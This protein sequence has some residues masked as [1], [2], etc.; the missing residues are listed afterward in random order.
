MA[1]ALCFV[2][3]IADAVLMHIVLVGTI[4]YGCLLETRTLTG[5]MHD[6]LGTGTVLI[7]RHVTCAIETMSAVHNC[8]ECFSF[9]LTMLVE[10]SDGPTELID[11]IRLRRLASA[12]AGD[13]H[14]SQHCCKDAG[15]DTFCCDL[16]KPV[17]CGDRQ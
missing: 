10:G 3:A 7:I 8:P 16:Q 1:A 6:C 17:P 15:V 4:T 11:S 9:M 13:L 2:N 5:D 14:A 12:P